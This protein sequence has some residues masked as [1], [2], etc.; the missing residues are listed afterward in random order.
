MAIEKKS[1]VGKTAKSTKTT[2]KS[3]AGKVATGSMKTTMRMAKGGPS[4]A[5]LKTTK[6]FNQ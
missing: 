5:G 3:A 2:T 1:L 6:V 4:P